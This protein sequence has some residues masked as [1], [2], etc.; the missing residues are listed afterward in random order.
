VSTGYLNWYYLKK[1]KDLIAILE[2]KP[3]SPFWNQG[4][5]ILSDSAGI[6]VGGDAGT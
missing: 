5:K 6:F 3:L 1:I 2:K 4:F